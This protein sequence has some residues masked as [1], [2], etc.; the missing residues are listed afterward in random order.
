L[1]LE[2]PVFIGVCHSAPVLGDLAKK[3]ANRRAED[4]AVLSGHQ[5]PFLLQGS[6][7]VG[8]ALSA[9]SFNAD[10][11]EEREGFTVMSNF[12][13]DTSAQHER[14]PNGAMDNCNRT[15][16]AGD[17][18]RQRLSPVVGIGAQ[19]IEKERNRRG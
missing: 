6:T 15:K 11:E 7:A 4:R 19:A 16:F 14:N 17:D 9:E 5:T 10:N 1:W 2:K 18:D 8:K 12:G 13:F 3:G